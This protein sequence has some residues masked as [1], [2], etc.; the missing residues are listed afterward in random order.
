MARSIFNNLSTNIVAGVQKSF[1][2]FS[3]LFGINFTRLFKIDEGGMIFLRIQHDN[4]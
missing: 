4:E 3:F 1:K 2:Y